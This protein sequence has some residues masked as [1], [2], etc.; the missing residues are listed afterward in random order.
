MTRWRKRIGEEGLAK[1]VRESLRI[2]HTEGALRTSDLKVV[3]VDTT[4]QPKAITFPTDA[5]LLYR[6]IVRLAAQCLQMAR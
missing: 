2:A 3:T 6:A 4:V 1:L 5:K